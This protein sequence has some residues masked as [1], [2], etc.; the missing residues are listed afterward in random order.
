MTVNETP[1]SGGQFASIK[2]KMGRFFKVSSRI[3]ME[4]KDTALDFFPN[5]RSEDFSLMITDGK[6]K[7][8]TIEVKGLTGEAEVTKEE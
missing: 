8:R 7:T 5:G 4:G 6:G 2:G 1:G 3:K